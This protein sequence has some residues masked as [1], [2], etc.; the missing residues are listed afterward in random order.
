MLRGTFIFILMATVP[1]T[2]RAGVS[3]FNLVY[4]ND[5]VKT[6]TTS[7]HALTAYDLSVGIPIGKRDLYVSLNYGSFTSNV[8]ATTNTTWV[9]TDMGLKLSG[10]FG[11]GKLY[12]SS[13]TYN[14]KSTVKYDDGTTATELRGTS[15]KFDFGV[16]YWMTEN[17]SLALKIYYYAPSMAEQV[18]STT[19][20]KVAYSRAT[21][22]QGLAFHFLF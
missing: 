20:T 2:S 7:S 1:W 18:D 10:F 14:L 16:N 4:S 12:S 9:G 11:K 8:T 22:G 5:S 6:A 17:M 15:L 21:M 3:D 19:L 13:L